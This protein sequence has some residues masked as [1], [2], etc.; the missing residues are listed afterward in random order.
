MHR[1]RARL[2]GGKVAAP[3]I[4]AIAQIPPL[5]FADRW[6]KPANRQSPTEN[7]RET[8]ARLV[9]ARLRVPGRPSV[10]RVR[11]RER[12]DKPESFSL[13]VHDERDRADHSDKPGT[14][15]VARA[16]RPPSSFLNQLRRRSTARAT[17]DGYG[18]RPVNAISFV[19]SSASSGTITRGP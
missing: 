11:L 2:R 14:G 7:D 8:I 13:T 18:R 15:V 19:C 4:Q 5:Q 3:A 17:S 12:R 9:R 16:D 10:H 6:A 1:V